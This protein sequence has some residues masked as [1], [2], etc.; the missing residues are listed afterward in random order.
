FPEEIRAHATSLFLA[1]HR[2]VNRP[3]FAVE[4]L[5]ALEAWNAKLDHDFSGIVAE[6]AQ[7]SSLLGYWIAVRAGATTTEGT[8]ESLDEDGQL[9]LRTADGALRAVGAGEATIVRRA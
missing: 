9:L 2:A 8:A 6:A 5:R 1:A 4:V 3:A 7:R